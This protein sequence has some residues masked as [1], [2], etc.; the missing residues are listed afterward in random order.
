M[1]V[2][3]RCELKKLIGRCG[4]PA[5]GSCVYCGR[6]FC[7][8]HGVLLEEHQQICQRKP[9]V[10]KREDLARHLVYRAQV[11]QRNGSRLCGVFDCEFGS[12]SQCSRCRG[13]FCE[14]HTQIREETPVERGVQISR[15]VS[16]CQHCWLRRPIWQRQ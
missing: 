12:A 8:E 9:C 14:R 5:I 13:F 11:H 10:A 7:A 3:Q 2:D 15:K 16:L 4:A 1:A 6:H